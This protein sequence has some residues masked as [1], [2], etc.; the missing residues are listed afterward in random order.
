MA[1]THTKTSGKPQPKPAPAVGRASWLLAAG[2]GVFVVGLALVIARALDPMAWY[3]GDAPVFAASMEFVRP[4]LSTPGGLTAAAGAWL[5][6]TAVDGWLGTMTLT[7]LLALIGATGWRLTRR[8]G[9][10]SWLWVLPPGAVLLAFSRYVPGPF[11]LGLLLFWLQTALV[12]W[13]EVARLGRLRGVI[14]AALALVLFYIAGP[15]PTLSFILAASLQWEREGSMSVLNRATAGLLLVIWLVVVWLGTGVDPAGLG[16][17]LGSRGLTIAAVLATFW[18]VL[19][20][21]AQLAIPLVLRG[22]AMRGA[23]L[24]RWLAPVFAAAM[25]MACVTSVDPIRRALL[26]IQS[27][28]ERQDWNGVVSAAKEL[29]YLPP[30]ARL[31]AQRALYHQGRLLDDLFSIPQRKGEDL[32]PT[33]MDGLAVSLPL[34]DTLIELGHVNLAEHYVHEAIEVR[35]ERPEI[36]W[37]LAWINLIKERPE[38]ARVFLNRLSWVPFHRPLAEHWLRAIDKDPTLFQEP[39][40]VT[41]RQRRVT[42]DQVERRFSTQELLGQSI[43]TSHGDPMAVQ[44]LMAYFLLTDE[45]EGIVRTMGQ[46]ASSSKLPRHVAEAVV[47]VQRRVGIVDLAGHSMDPDIVARFNRFTALASRGAQGANVETALRNEFGDTF[48]FY[49]LFGRTPGKGARL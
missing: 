27:R 1:A 20:S 38:A 35:G 12:F 48:W 33:L 9:A 40:V 16:L 13:Q 17:R 32:F 21:A 30:E 36:L 46:L 28:A 34:F 2:W 18:C 41:A 15:L 37:R 4:L 19:C 45:P 49:E 26:R 25:V 8:D 3:Y 22:R 11:E 14:L 10:G 6:Q 42:V 5:G 7:G 39:S 23:A 24:A 31:Q 44:Y 47:G 29:P 43:Q